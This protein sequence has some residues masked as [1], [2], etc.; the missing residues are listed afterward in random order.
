MI[1]QWS[2]CS[3]IGACGLT[4]D[5]KADLLRLKVIDT[6]LNAL[7]YWFIGQ[8]FFFGKPSGPFSGG[9]SN[10]T[11][12]VI[13]FHEELLISGDS[14]WELYFAFASNTATIGLSSFLIICRAERAKKGRR[15]TF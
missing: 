11:D 7:S 13:L 5:G 2:K 3:Q 4:E 12:L 14:G 8:A 1:Y 10:W 6:A 9:F 15:A